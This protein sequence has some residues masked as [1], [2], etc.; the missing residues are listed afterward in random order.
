MY[1]FIILHNLDETIKM[2][3]DNNIESYYFVVTLKKKNILN[4]TAC[5][6][7]QLSTIALTFTINLRY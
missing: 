3:L 2:Q 5:E 4:D 1:A 7:N 6:P